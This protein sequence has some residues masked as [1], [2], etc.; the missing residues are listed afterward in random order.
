MPLGAELS[1]KLKES[2]LGNLVARGYTLET[3][4]AAHASK[5]AQVKHDLAIAGADVQEGGVR[6]EIPHQ[7]PMSIVEIMEHEL[8]Q[9]GQERANLV[10]RAGGRLTVALRAGRATPQLVNIARRVLCKRW[11]GRVLGRGENGVG[12]DPLLGGSRLTGTL[13]AGALPILLWWAHR[14]IGRQPPVQKGSLV[15]HCVD[16]LEIWDDLLVAFGERHVN[17]RDREVAPLIEHVALLILAPFDALQRRV[18]LA[19]PAVNRRPI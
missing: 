3:D 5:E 13:G 8:T 6:A 11:Q 15:D 10:A 12:V 4:G 7:A 19:S 17:A 1:L 9:V 14:V 2:L 16:A 18:R